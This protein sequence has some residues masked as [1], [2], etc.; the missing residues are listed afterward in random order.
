MKII[1]LLNKIINGE[2]IPEKIKVDDRL[3]VTEDILNKE[4][5]IIEEDKKIEK[6]D[7]HIPCDSPN[8]IYN[9]I[10]K[11]KINEIIEELNRRE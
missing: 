6:L 7:L 5:E 3:F 11:N 9:G 8:A 4:V 2:E 10:F 1:N